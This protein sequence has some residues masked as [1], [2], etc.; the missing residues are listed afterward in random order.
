MLGESDPSVMTI[1][2]G[3]KSEQVADRFI[4]PVLVVRQPREEPA[5]AAD[6]SAE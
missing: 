4:G 1:L 2:F 3:E 5:D 6:G